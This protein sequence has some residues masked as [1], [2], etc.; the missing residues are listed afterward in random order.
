MTGFLVLLVIY[1][2]FFGWIS[3]A[4]A[5]NKGLDEKYAFRLGLFFGIIGFI[6]VATTPSKK[7]VSDGSR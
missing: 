6:I 3:Q 7:G 4:I 5:V 2:L 1:G